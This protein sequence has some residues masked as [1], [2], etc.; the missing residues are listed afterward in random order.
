MEKKGN[1]EISKLKSN[2]LLSSPTCDLTVIYRLLIIAPCRV[3]QILHVESQ[4]SRGHFK[5]W[6]QEL[7]A[8]ELFT[9]FS[10]FSLLFFS[11]G[12]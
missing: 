2:A 6:G 11:L 1:E 10:N 7:V 4:K 8:S 5:L 12:T 9:K 3:F